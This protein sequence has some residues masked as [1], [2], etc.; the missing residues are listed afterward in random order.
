MLFRSQVVDRIFEPFFT[1]KHPGQGTGLGLSI[2]YGIVAQNGGHIRVESV[3]GAGSCFQIFLPCCAAPQP[4]SEAAPEVSEQPAPAASGTILLV[5]DEESILRPTR[6]TLERLGFRVLATVSA[7]EAIRLFEAERK[8]VD[9]LITDVIMPDM[10]G[11]ELVRELLRRQPGLKHLFISGHTA[12][13]LSGAGLGAPPANCI[14][15]PFS[16]AAL[17]EK[18]REILSGQTAGV[19]SE[20]RRSQNL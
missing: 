2:V 18:V 9:L 8:P 13:L 5:D 11:P 19:T 12:N 6:R 16:H 7:S 15:K 20:T 3:P 1:T 10:S 14:Q 4:E 17:A